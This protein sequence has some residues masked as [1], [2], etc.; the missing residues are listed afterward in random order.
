MKRLLSK[1][2][3]KPWSRL[4][5]QATQTSKEKPQRLAQSLQNTDYH[6]EQLQ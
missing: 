3:F 1:I 5:N 6:S 4:Q 2:R